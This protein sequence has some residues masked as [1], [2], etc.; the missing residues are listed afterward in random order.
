MGQVLR[1]DKIGTLSHSAGN[2]LMAASVSNPA[3]LTIGGQQFK[4]TSQLSVALPA[5]SA[6]TRYQVFAVQTAGVVSLVISLNENSVGPVGYSR[7]KLVGSLMANG[8][9]SV[10]FGSFINISGTPRS[11]KIDGGLV[12]VTAE[13]VN[14]TKGVTKE[15]DIFE[16][17]MIGD[18]LVGVM[19][20]GQ[21]VAGVSG[22]GA[23]RYNMPTNL[24]IDSTKTLIGTDSVADNVTTL[25]RTGH[26]SGPVTIAGGNASDAN[27]SLI[28]VNVAYF[29]GVLMIGNDAGGETLY[30]AS[31][32]SGRKNF[33]Q[34]ALSFAARVDVYI[35]GWSNTAIEDL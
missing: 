26:A 24:L 6:N 28:P 8:A 20:Y 21:T 34:T 14:P 23:Y 13:S 7:W 33:G 5:M 2:I 19:R 31:A 30:T 9:L 25:A 10:S 3:Y 32:N 27:L 17:E 18:R 35:Q 15:I 29:R 16:Y 22:T 4:V 12:N 11:G 1:I